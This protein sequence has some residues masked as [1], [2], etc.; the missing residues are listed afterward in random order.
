MNDRSIEENLNKVELSTAAKNFGQVGSTG[1]ER[2]G[3][4]VYEEFIP[5]LRLPQNLK[6]YKEMSSNDATIGGILFLFESMMKK[7]P[8][9]VKPGGD[10]LVDKTATKFV[11]ECMDDMEHSWM[12]FIVEA[13]SMFI[14]GWAW[15]EIVYKVRNNKNSKYPDGRIGW[16]KLPIRSQNSWNSWVYDEKDPDK[17]IGMEQLDNNA[18]NKIV[19]IPYEKSLLFRT[20]SYRN[21]PEGVS[22]LRTAYRCVS[23]DT[24]ILTPKGWINI[25]DLNKKDKV[26][27]LNAEK[28]RIETEPVLKMNEYDYDGEL[29]NAKSRYVDQLVTPN[30]RMWVKRYGKENYEFIEAKDCLKSYS[31]KATSNLAI[32]GPKK[33]KLGS[34][35]VDV[36]LWAKFLG[37]WMAEGC[38]WEAKEGSSNPSRR[39]TCLCQN[40][41]EVSNDIRWVLDRLPWH[42]GEKRDKRKSKLNRWIGTH[43][44]L[45]NELAYLGKARTK[46]VPDYVFKWAKEDIKTFLLYYFKGDGSIAGNL[47]DYKGTKILFTASKQLA[48][49]LMHLGFLAGY[50]P[51]V[52]LQTL[53]K[54][55]FSQNELYVVTLGKE[56][57]DRMQAKWVK[58]KYKGKVYCPTTNN[59]IIY[60]RRNGKCSWTGNSWFYKKRIEEIEGI[61]IERDLAGLPVITVPEGIDIWDPDNSQ[62]VILKAYLEKLVSNIRRDKNEGVLLPAGYEF[63]LATSGSSRQ[64]DTTKIIDRYD[65]RIAMTVLADII[66]MG[67]TN[68]GSFALAKSKT[69]MLGASLEAMAD[70]IKNII[71]KVAIP[72]LMDLNTFR[73]CTKYPELIRGEIEAPDT[74]KL[75]DAMQR[76]RDMGMAWFP[77]EKT[78]DYIRASMGLP[79]LT[80]EEKKELKAQQE[81]EQAEAKAQQQAMSGRESAEHETDDKGDFNSTYEEAGMKKFLKKLLGIKKGDE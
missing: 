32:R 5:T 16:A 60:I 14:Y 28:D 61:G 44:E 9:S 79:V 19:T 7:L 68:S 43:S 67:H 12:D 75:G 18:I 3:G 37:I 6:V 30:H 53:S 38:T 27:T 10:K 74:A 8:W 69:N 78:E 77:N 22:L 41:G 52:R 21:S 1:L 31:F 13:L 66:L 51:S 26:Y 54:G 65:Q 55:R 48:E 42:F 50:R 59:G 49:D 15:H 46:F 80:E 39:E 63:E 57:T 40:E 20:K 29:I 73:G 76:F 45:Y 24:D 56:F 36:N 33:I 34:Y 23:D 17:L 58:V 2:Y 72:K 70:N 62:G 25:V 11:E 64:F 47:K 71:N 4:Y 35:K 81:K